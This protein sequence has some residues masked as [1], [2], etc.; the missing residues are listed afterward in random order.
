MSTTLL[1]RKSSDGKTRGLACLVPKGSSSARLCQ[2][3]NAVGGWLNNPD[4]LA[5]FICAWRD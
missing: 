1:D 4:R 3:L 5:R 2:Q